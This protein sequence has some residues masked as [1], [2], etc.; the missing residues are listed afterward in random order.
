MISKIAIGAV[1]LASAT[2]L[3]VDREPLLSWS[4]KPPKSHPVD[5]FVP[6]FG[7]DEDV[8][9]TVESYQSEERRQGVNW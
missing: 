2:K 1:A 4:P 7:L 6:N 5:Y 9:G 3:T 8:L